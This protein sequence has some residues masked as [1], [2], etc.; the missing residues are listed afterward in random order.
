MKKVFPV[1]LLVIA[2]GVSLSAQ[3]ASSNPFTGG[4]WQGRVSYRDSGGA[5]RSEFYELILVPDGTCI[6]TVS[7]NINSLFYS[8]HGLNI[9]HKKI[10]G[11]R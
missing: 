8:N 5:A 10:K 9:Q 6:V 3:S 4:H 1:F 2:A 7:G 11:K